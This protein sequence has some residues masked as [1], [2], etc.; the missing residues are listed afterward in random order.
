MDDFTGAIRSNKAFL[1][2]C[3]DG[4]GRRKEGIYEGIETT[5][6]VA[7]ARAKARGLEV[8]TVHHFG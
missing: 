7:I 6:D 4:K 3:K 1:L 2:V 5:L 8:V